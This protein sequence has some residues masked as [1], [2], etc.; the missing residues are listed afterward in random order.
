MVPEAWP[1]ERVAVKMWHGSSVRVAGGRINLSCSC[2]KR[3]VISA[4]AIAALI[5]LTLRQIY[6]ELYTFRIENEYLGQAPMRNCGQL[7]EL[8]ATFRSQST[9]PQRP[10]PPPNKIALVLLYDEN[11]APQ[12]AKRSLSQKKLYAARHGYRGETEPACKPP[13]PITNKWLWMQ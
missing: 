8:A 13:R 4:A 11:Y 7:R 1:K 6:D 5:F 2:S 10:W 3:R 12:F 9:V